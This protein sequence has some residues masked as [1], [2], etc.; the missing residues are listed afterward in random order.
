MD[1][2]NIDKEK[3]ERSDEDLLAHADRIMDENDSLFKK[4]AQP[5]ISENENYLVVDN[6]QTSNDSSV[7]IID[8]N[9]VRPEDDIEFIDAIVDKH[10]KKYDAVFKAL[11]KL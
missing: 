7:K 10:F 2:L 5:I 4:L 1:L 8:K 3:N 9:Q 11:T 6:M